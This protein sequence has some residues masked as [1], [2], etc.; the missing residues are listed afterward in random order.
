MA[1]FSGAGGGELTPVVLVHF[2]D[3]R[4][5]GW[6]IGYLERGAD[7]VDGTAATAAGGNW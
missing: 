4:N 2:G 6:D 3:C 7:E 1:G 5:Y